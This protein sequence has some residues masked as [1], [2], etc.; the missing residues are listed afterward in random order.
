MHVVGLRESTDVNCLLSTMSDRGAWGMNPEGHLQASPPDD[1]RAS[2]LVH[3]GSSDAV[4]ALRAA[5]SP[6]PTSPIARRFRIVCGR[7]WHRVPQLG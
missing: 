5:T 2:P 7:C 3:A 6:T 4:R 1:L